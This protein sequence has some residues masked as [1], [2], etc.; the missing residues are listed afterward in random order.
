MSINNDSLHA[1]KDYESDEDDYDDSSLE[2]CQ[3]DRAGNPSSRNR[4]VEKLPIMVNCSMNLVIT[5]ALSLSIYLLMANVFLTFNKFS[6][7]QWSKSGILLGQLNGAGG[8]VGEARGNG[9]SGSGDKTYQYYD[10]SKSLLTL[11]EC[12]LLNSYHDEYLD[13]LRSYLTRQ[14]EP[15]RQQHNSLKVNTSFFVH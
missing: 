13:S 5:F 15:H 8:F 4:S 12:E 3:N 14:H 1:S 2:T 10:C 6:S 11:E 9:A 7:L